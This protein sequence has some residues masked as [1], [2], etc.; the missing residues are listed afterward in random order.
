M[1]GEKYG[2]CEALLKPS[3]RRIAS[4]EQPDTVLVLCNS[5]AAPPLRREQRAL[6][7]YAEAGR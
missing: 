5:V 3:L 4:D 7:H 1:K 6:A 2:L